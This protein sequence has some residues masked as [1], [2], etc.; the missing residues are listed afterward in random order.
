MDTIPWSFVDKRFIRPARK[1]PQSQ[2]PHTLTIGYQLTVAKITSSDPNR[3][4]W[5]KTGIWSEQ[6]K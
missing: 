5:K 4:E 3:G 6:E 2:I 1:I